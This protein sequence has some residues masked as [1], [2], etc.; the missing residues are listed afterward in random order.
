MR[1][2]FAACRL[3]WPAFVLPFLFVWSPTLLLQGSPVDVA[4]S[5]VTAIGGVWIGSAALAGFLFRVLSPYRRMWG[6]LAAALMLL[7]NDAFAGVI[8]LELAGLVLALGLVLTEMRHNHAAKSV[9]A[10]PAA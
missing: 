7:P 1:V 9:P 3:G 6:G 4:V 5:V 10:R 2:G 8:W